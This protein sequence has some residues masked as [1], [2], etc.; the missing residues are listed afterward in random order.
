MPHHSAAM[1]AT[2]PGATYD[3][4]L[5]AGDLHLQCCTACGRQVF[6][7]RTI[8]NFC[9]SNALEW[10][11]PSGDGVVYS[12][13]VVRQRPERGGDYN[14]AIIELAEGARM[15]ARVIDILPERVSIGMSVS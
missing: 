11:R 3:A 13:T 12:T 7:P 15:L 4:F 2:S 9:G 5:K 14:I 1:D 8:C 6:Y 10:R